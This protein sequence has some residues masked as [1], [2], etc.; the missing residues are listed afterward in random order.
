MNYLINNIY[1]YIC[2]YLLIPFFILYKS[3][4]FGRNLYNLEFLSKINTDKL[5]GLLVLII[6]FHHVA[7]RM[8]N[9]GLMLPFRQAG[10]HTVSIF[11]FLSGYGLM[12]SN[13]QNPNYLK[14]F[15][16]KR[17][18]KVYVPFLI[19]NI[20]TIFA[21]QLVFDTDY[22]LMDK[23]FYATGVKLIDSVTWYVVVTLIFYVVFYILFRYFPNHLGIKLLFLSALI[24]YIICYVV[25]LGSWWYINSFC[26]PIGVYTALN[27]NTI[28]NH[29]KNNY[30]KYTVF[31][32]I[33]FVSLSSGISSALLYFLFNF[34]F[35][36]LLETLS[37]ALFILVVLSLLFK[38]DLRHTLLSFFGRASYEMYLIHMKI[39]NIL[40]GFIQI[41]KGYNI[42]LY[43][44]IILI[45]SK[46]IL[47]FERPVARSI[48][49]INSRIKYNFQQ[50]LNS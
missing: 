9:V 47:L 11:F 44:V 31:F 21:Y 33:C 13:L 48:S 7:Q 29:L 5:R 20:I 2:A 28:S 41:N 30:M 26:F 22:S 39:Y 45:A 43:I 23:I 18:S 36:V 37:S 3:K 10:I 15:I 42:F 1:I 19:I 4:I 8:D 35:K 12:S 50:F 25:G 14:N 34:H 24:F 16:F 27:F 6:I 49:V 17:T 40:S 46:V 38:I 32:I